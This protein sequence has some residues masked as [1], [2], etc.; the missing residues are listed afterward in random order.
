MMGQTKNHSNSEQDFKPGMEPSHGNGQAPAPDKTIG[1]FLREAREKKRLSYDQI[2]EVTRI[3]PPILKA[4][5]D[6]SW[7]SLP[8]T[9][10]VSGFV[11]SYANALG[12]EE[13]K[14]MAFFRESGPSEVSAPKPLVEPG[15]NT[16]NF[17]VILIL[18]L[19]SLVLAYFLWNGYSTFNKFLGN[20]LATHPVETNAVESEKDQETLGEIGSVTSTEEFPLDDAVPETHPEPKY[21]EQ[22]DDIQKHE[23]KAED[24]PVI[25]AFEDIPSP[26][27]TLKV[28]IR[29][30]T[31][32]RIFVDDQDPKEY[33]FR[34]QENFEWKAKKGFEVLIG[35]ASGIDLEF[36]GTRIENHGTPGQ[37]V[38]L[39]FPTGYERRPT[40]D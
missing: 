16:K 6:E 29:E 9:A 28:S 2:W 33:I 36:N 14:V 37:V 4:L 3:R 39:T 23:E 1:A 21:T 15:R 26:E 32:L 17:L 20:L 27:L 22:T 10:F 31:W 19:L 30:T 18:V 34:P 25:A 11:R 7:E 40:Q 35:N 8:S 13:Q 38:C 12:L 24:S 5:E